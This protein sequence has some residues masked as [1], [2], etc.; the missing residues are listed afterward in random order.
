MTQPRFG[1]HTLGVGVGFRSGTILL[2]KVASISLKPHGESCVSIKAN[3][4]VQIV[5]LLINGKP[6]KD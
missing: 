5:D 6:W 3:G 2:P 1:L 4:K